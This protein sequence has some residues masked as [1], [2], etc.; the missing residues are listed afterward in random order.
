[1]LKLSIAEVCGAKFHIVQNAAKNSARTQFVVG[2]NNTENKNAAQGQVLS[3]NDG[4]VEDGI[5]RCYNFHLKWCGPDCKGKEAGRLSSLPSNYKCASHPGKRSQHF[6]KFY[7]RKTQYIC[8]S[9]SRFWENWYKPF[10]Y[11]SC[12]YRFRKPKGR[13]ALSTGG[14]RLDG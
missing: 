3:T 2:M 11:F 4:Q 10:L 13:V 14:E 1:M 7:F 8:F 9:I 5:R 6:Q 12:S